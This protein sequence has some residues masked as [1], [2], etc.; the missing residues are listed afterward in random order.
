MA[1]TNVYNREQGESGAEEMKRERGERGE[2]RSVGCVCAVRL[3]VRCVLQNRVQVHSYTHTATRGT[4]F[5]VEEQYAQTTAKLT[6]ESSCF[7]TP[8]IYGS[9][10]FVVPI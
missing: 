7:S 2:R 6:Q 8:H 1:R 10:L 4:T 5:S 3:C 9:N